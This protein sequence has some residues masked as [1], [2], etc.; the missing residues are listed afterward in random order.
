MYFISILKQVYLIKVR[1]F[2]RNIDNTIAIFNEM[3]LSA[4]LI[5][6]NFFTDANPNTEILH[7]CDIVLL[8]IAGV[9]GLV[10]FGSYAVSALLPILRKLFKYLRVKKQTKNVKVYKHSEIS[11]NVSMGPN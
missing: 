7:T 6:F 4:Y 1:P 11:T 5:T 8:G 2:K 9:F 10:N 3:L